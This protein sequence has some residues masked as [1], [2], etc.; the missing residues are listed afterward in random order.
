MVEAGVIAR[1]K[2]P[3]VGKGVFSIPNQRYCKELEDVIA[4]ANS[5]GYLLPTDYQLR[6]LNVYINELKLNRIWSKSDIHYVFGYGGAN[7]IYPALT[8]GAG[9]PYRRNNL[10]DFSKLNL[11]NPN[12]FELTRGTNGATNK[13][14]YPY[15][16]TLGWKIGI[17]AANDTGYLD[18]G[19]IIG[20]NNVKYTLNDA[21]ISFYMST[22]DE[23]TGNDTITGFSDSVA[24]RTT[25]I[26][27]SNGTNILVRINT[28]G[29]GANAISNT[30]SQ[31]YYIVER[32]ASNL[33][34]VYKNGVSIGTTARA[35]LSLANTYPVYILSQNNTGTSSG[36]WLKNPLSFIRYGASLGATLQ[37]TDYEIFTAFRTK[38]GYQ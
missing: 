1:T 10:G 28:S 37:K 15:H 7:S 23:G 21:G 12:Q 16:S 19:W 13:L 30:T 26:V 6:M 24:G 34:T 17:G 33:T 8:F 4:V 27:P 22:F 3:N 35:S 20:V 9:E 38:L 36:A 25:T 11:I 32:T 31:G 2:Y 5:K 29:A 14:S 18:T